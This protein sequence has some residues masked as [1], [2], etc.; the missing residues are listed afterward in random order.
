MHFEVIIIS[1][2]I[3]FRIDRFAQNY[4]T[5]RWTT[6][7]YSIEIEFRISNSLNMP[8]PSQ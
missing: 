6:L 1:K 8:K 3:D 7:A 5:T 2:N 4:I